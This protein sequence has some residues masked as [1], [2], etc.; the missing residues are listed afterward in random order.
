MHPSII[1]IRL[2]PGLEPI[3]ADFWTRGE[4][5]PAHYRAHRDKQ[6]LFIIQNINNYGPHCGAVVSTVEVLLVSAWVFSG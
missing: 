2:S 1:L 5:Q 6:P 3:P 4:V